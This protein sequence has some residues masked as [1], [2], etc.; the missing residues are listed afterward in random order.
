MSA[1]GVTVLVMGES[2]PELLAECARALGPVRSAELYV[3]GLSGA[4]NDRGGAAYQALSFTERHV[5][6]DGEREAGRQQARARAEAERTIQLQPRASDTARAVSIAQFLA[7]N[8]GVDISSLTPRV[9]PCYT[10]LPGE[11][12]GICRGDRDGGRCLD[13]PECLFR[14]R[15]GFFTRQAG[16]CPWCGEPLPGDLGAAR[17]LGAVRAD[18][19]IDHIVPLARGGPAH[20]EWNKQLLHRGCNSSKGDQ[21][22]TGAVALAAEHDIKVL[23]FLAVRQHPGPMPQEAV[24]HL[25][26]P[27]IHGKDGIFRLTSARIGH[28]FRT[29]C[30]LNLGVEWLPVH[31][32]SLAATCGRCLEQRDRLGRGNAPACP[33]ECCALAP[34]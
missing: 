25:L 32:S 15:A 27:L 7:D 13:T 24:V 31:G 18:V 4:Y 6:W 21:V 20:A 23:D 10:Y 17:Y 3:Q 22:T 5:V 16:G 26:P 12:C 19:A 29:L 1:L 8:P 11:E 14:Y 9:F 34:S 28:R 30:R 2:S 33:G